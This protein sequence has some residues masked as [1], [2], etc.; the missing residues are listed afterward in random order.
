MSGY[1]E[2]NITDDD[3]DSVFHYSDLGKFSTPGQQCAHQRARL[4]LESTDDVLYT[5]GSRLADPS[6]RTQAASNAAYFDGTYHSTSAVNASISFNFTGA[7]TSLLTH[8]RRAN[9]ASDTFVSLAI[10]TGSDIYVYG[11]SGPSF[12]SIEIALDGASSASTVV[13]AY[14][15]NTTVPH[16]VY[17]AHNLSTPSMHQLVMKNLGPRSQEEGSSMLLD[18]VKTTVQLA[19]QG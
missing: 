13:S 8:R 7:C 4:A 14:A 3:F 6:N 16:L 5:P 9:S 2:T 17:E 12:G 11:A 1:I 15:T 10:H 19:P 18:F